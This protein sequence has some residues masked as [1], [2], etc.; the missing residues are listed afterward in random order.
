[1][2]TTLF[3]VRAALDHVVYGH[4]STQKKL[5][6]KQDPLKFPILSNRDYWY[7]RAATSTKSK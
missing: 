3:N 5:T 1:L 6:A 2:A 4:A 7:A